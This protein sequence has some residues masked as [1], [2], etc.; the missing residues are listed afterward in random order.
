MVKAVPD[1]NVW[2]SAFNFGGVP[3]RIIEVGVSGELRLA[4]SDEILAEVSRVQTHKFNW[5]PDRSKEWEGDILAFTEKVLP[6]KRVDVISADPTDNRILE[7]AVAAEAAYIVTGDKHLLRL[8]AFV[9]TQII[10]PA[11]L[12]ARVRSNPR[13]G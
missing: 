12:L 2:I 13:S 6:V 9:K 3:R 5:S 4:T 1:S 11:D 7:C 10:T 8:L